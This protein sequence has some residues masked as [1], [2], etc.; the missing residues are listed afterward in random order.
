M[1]ETGRKISPKIVLALVAILIVIAGGVW[2]GNNHKSTTSPSGTSK[3]TASADWATYKSDQYGIQFTYL[4]S[5]GE[6]KI[7]VT[8]PQ[9]GKHYDVS[10]DKSSSAKN[11]VVVRMAIDSA[12]AQSQFCDPDG[13]CQTEN[14]I[15]KATLESQMKTTAGLV[16]VT[17]TSFTVVDNAPKEKISHFATYQIVNLSKINATAAIANYSI[18]NGATNCPEAKLANNS[19]TGCVTVQNYNDVAKMLNSLNTI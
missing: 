18:V 3:T 10:F 8:S 4:K 13:R 6:P 1:E 2:F 5:W 19:V 11:N 15:T 17:T 12:D 7:T 14:G 9:I 16:Q